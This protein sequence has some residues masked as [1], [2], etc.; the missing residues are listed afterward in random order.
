[1]ILCNFFFLGEKGWHMC[2][3]CWSSLSPW[4]FLH[5]HP[6][7]SHNMC[8]DARPPGACAVVISCKQ[9]KEEYIWNT[10]SKKAPAVL[11]QALRGVVVL[12]NQPPVYLPPH[13]TLQFASTSTAPTHC[14]SLV[15]DPYVQAPKPRHMPLPPP[16]CQE[17]LACTPF[18]KFS[19]H[20]FLWH[21]VW[22]A[23]CSQLSMSVVQL[24]SILA[25]V[26]VCVWMWD[27]V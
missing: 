2:I 6:S 27:C 4:S 9:P 11:S 8:P 22:P 1:M 13:W 26:C 10:M 18:Q 25:C 16:L 20:I 15:H 19:K 12:S 5:C 21:S 3:T 17:A 14:F 23:I 7:W 24:F